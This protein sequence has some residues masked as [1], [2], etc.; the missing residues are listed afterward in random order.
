MLAEL[1]RDDYL[2]VWRDWHL[3]PPEV[4]MNAE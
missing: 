3:P 1:S 2:R 4:A